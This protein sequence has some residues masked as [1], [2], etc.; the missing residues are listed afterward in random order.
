MKDGR[1]HAAWQAPDSPSA[2]RSLV[3]S[4]ALSNPMVARMISKKAVCSVDG[5]DEFHY[6]KGFCRLHYKRHVAGVVQTNCEVCGNLTKRA[7]SRFCTRSCRMKWHRK[8]G[9][10]TEEKQ[11]ISR[12]ECSV[13]GCVDPVHANGYCRTHN[14]R[15]RR[16]GNPL[17]VKRSP[18]VEN[19]V[20]CGAKRSKTGAKKELCHR[21][22]HNAYYHA[23]LETER[24]RR[25]ARRGH[26]R[27]ATPPWADLEAIR[28]IYAACPPGHEVD[29]VLPIRGKRVSGLHVETNLQYLPVLANRMK[30]NRMIA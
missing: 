16:Y 27:K 3:A 24:P 7:A 28:R 19:C 11:L 8:Y 14:M 21:C 1:I 2:Y 6:G 10:Y 25:N 5:C 29:H 26:L 9:C 22:Y 23:N 4:C 15:M 12:G 18:R 13:D 30:S 17:T 20:K